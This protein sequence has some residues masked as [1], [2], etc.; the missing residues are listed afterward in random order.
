[1]EI[2]NKQND[3]SSFLQTLNGWNNFK[4]GFFIGACGSAGFAYI[5]LSS[6][7]V[8]LKN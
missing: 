5:C 6:I 7:P 2:T 3:M 8:F 1:M 4:S